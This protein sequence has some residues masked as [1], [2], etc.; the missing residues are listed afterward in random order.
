MNSLL[1]RRLGNY[2]VRGMNN[3]CCQTDRHS[4]NFLKV[5]IKGLEGDKEN[6]LLFKIEFLND[7]VV[8][9]ICS[10]FR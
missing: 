1:K 6:L 4:I 10:V 2:Y 5:Y 9:E 8:F 3:S 7:L